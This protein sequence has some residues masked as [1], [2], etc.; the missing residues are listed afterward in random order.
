MAMAQSLIHWVWQRRMPVYLLRGIWVLVIVWYEL[1]TFHYSSLLCQWPLLATQSTTNVMDSNKHVLIVADPQIPDR[2]SYPDRPVVIQALSQFIVDMNLRKSWQ[3]L[4]WVGKRPDVI[5]FAGDMM[6]NGRADVSL[7]EY[8][9]YYSRFR[10]I[11]RTYGIP[12]LYIP[13]NHDVDLKRVH[14]SEEAHSRYLAHF[15][16]LNQVTQVGNHTLVLIDALGLVEEDYARMQASQSFRQWQSKPGGTI[17]FVSHFGADKQHG[18][19]TILFTHVPLYRPNDASCGP[20]RERGNIHQGGGIDAGYQNIVG[21]SASEFILENI[22]PSL[23]FS[24]DD[25]D[26]C[27]IL[28]PFHDHEVLEVTVKSM[29]I[30]MGVQRPGVQLLTLGSEPSLSQCQR[31]C[32]LPN[33][34]GIYLNIYLPLFLISLLVLML[35]NWR[36]VATRTQQLEHDT[37][38]L[39]PSHRSRYSEE[40][41]MNFDAEGDQWTSLPRHNRTRSSSKGLE[42]TDGRVASFCVSIFTG[43]VTKQTLQRT[44]LRGFGMD[45]LTVAV[46]PLIVFFALA[47]LSGVMGA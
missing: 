30:A 13:G 6:D 26:A 43:R 47:W 7:V 29:S 27:E 21:K 14:S 19:K 41:A 36:R 28:H 34:L 35:S 20:N 32:L 45:C 31:L 42:W 17:E 15:G 9:E 25:H 22:K 1:G 44:F 12:A 18:R 16:P 37:Y 3:A 4:M 2:H 33:Q 10:S 46:V 11:F 38:R 40:D 39:A 24:G 5:V 23:V 8:Q